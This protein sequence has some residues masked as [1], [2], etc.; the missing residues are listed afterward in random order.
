MIETIGQAPRDPR[1]LAR[2]VRA[3]L[4]A[5][6]ATEVGMV[7]LSAVEIGRLM[8]GAAELSVGGRLAYFMTMAAWLATYIL[9][10]ALA[11]LW[12][13]RANRNAAALASDKSVSPIWSIAWFFI[14][15]ANFVMPFRA[16][17]ET[18]RISQSPTNWR[19]TPLPERVS[20]W[21]GLLL[22]NSLLSVMEGYPGE[23]GRD[24]GAQMLSME[25]TLLAS[26]MAIGAA[27][28]MRQIVREVS[29]AQAVA[30]NLPPPSGPAAP[31]VVIG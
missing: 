10:V 9:M 23:A 2:A 30:L 29:E 24:V 11:L 16:M 6:A 4:V 28:L 5:Y 19:E 20:L 3:I 17:S 12:F 31:A 27:L 1:R 21:W 22:L 25:L 7:I 14:P 15:I 18:W 8:N 26:C 13:Y